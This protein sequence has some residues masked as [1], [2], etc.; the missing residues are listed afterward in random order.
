MSKVFHDKFQMEC[1]FTEEGI[2]FC[3]SKRSVYFPYGCLDSLNLSFLGVMQAMSR[4][5]VCCFT[6][7]KQDKAEIKDL[8]KKAREA[9]KTAA[10]AE[11]VII[12]HEQIH[13]DQSLSPEEQLKQYKAQFVQGVLSKDQYDFMKKKLT[14]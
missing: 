5:Q 12:D 4:A 2:T 6:V 10:R 7:E 9:M 11:A 13:V 3:N 1:S 14:A 8:V